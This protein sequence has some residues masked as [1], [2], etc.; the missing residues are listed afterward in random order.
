M[1][2]TNGGRYADIVKRGLKDL[3]HGDKQ[4]EDRLQVRYP[5]YMLPYFRSNGLTALA[6][7][8]TKALRW[9]D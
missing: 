1:P 2:K 4:A 6:K 7:K 3:K 5:D 8:P 9:K